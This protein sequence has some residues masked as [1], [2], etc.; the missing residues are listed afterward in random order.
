MADG[1]P[2]RDITVRML[3]NHSSGL[4]GTH[5]P[6]VLTVVPVSG[7]AAQVQDT[8]ATERLKHK[9][10]EMAAYCSDGFTLVELVTAAIA[11]HPYT[12]FVEKEIL[13]PL[14][15][16]HSRFAQE[17]F[18]AWH[19]CPRAGC[20]GTARPASICQCLFKWTLYDTERWGGWR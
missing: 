6:Y 16:N 8:L 19:L 9:P 17:P 12:A 5:F 13:E 10:G 7:Y 15:M 20:C 14:G 4:P 18:D 1:E 11:G 3:L 2:W